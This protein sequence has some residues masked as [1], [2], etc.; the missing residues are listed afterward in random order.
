MRVRYLAQEN[1]RLFLQRMKRL[2]RHI[3]AAVLPLLFLLPAGNASA[4]SGTGKLL[5]MRTD[6]K[7]TVFMDAIR[8]SRI[9]EKLPR[10]K[11]RDWKKYYR[12]VY[13]FNKVYPLALEA[14]S[15][16]RQV[17][18]TVSTDGLKRGKKEK[19]IKGVQKNLFDAYE[20]TIRNMTV[21]QGALLMRLVDREC[22]LTPYEVIRDY[23]NGMA[24]GF[25]QGI[26]KLF[27]TDMK[28]HYDP[29]GEDAEI[30]DLVTKWEEGDF[31]NFYYSL[32][33]EWPEHVEIKPDVA[34]K[35]R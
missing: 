8:P 7:D 24:A 18:S 32:F 20:G 23:R 9:Y 14:R 33:W 25:W 13:N 29:K 15:I 3:V 21:S 31:D 16:I 4:Q 28:R 34:S 30:E 11:G 22:G 35:R 1:K 26:A 10:Q 17:D 6:G 19:Y 2:A 5:E 12:L 27:G